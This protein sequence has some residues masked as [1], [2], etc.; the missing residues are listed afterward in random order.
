MPSRSAAVAAAVAVAEE[1]GVRVAEPEVLHDSFSLRVLLR[2]APVVARVPTTTAL[3]RPRPADALGR[4]MAVVSFLR[5]AGAPVVPPSDLLPAGP[6]VHDGIAVTFWAHVRH[7]PARVVTPGEAGRMLAELHAALRGFPGELP[8]LGPVLDEPARLLDLL[9][10]AGPELV[11]AGELARLREAHAALRERLDGP[12][13]VQAVHG[14]AHPGNLL[15][16][17]AGLLWNDFEE[18]MA[19]PAAWDL[20]VLLRTTRLDGRAAVRAYGADPGD[21]AL[22]AFVAARGLQGTLWVLARALRFPERAGEARAVLETWL[23]DPSGMTR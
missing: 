21:P 22:R 3:G 12:A 2:P 18:C 7:D 1:H 15:A 23:R 8:Y 20:A 19:A 10:G 6:H 11:G 13:G 9:A 17:P 5:A 14:D 4:E 16:T